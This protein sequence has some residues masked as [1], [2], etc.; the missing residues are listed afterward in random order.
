MKL[1]D[2]AQSTLELVLKLKQEN[3]VETCKNE[4]ALKVKLSLI[5]KH[6]SLEKA[7]EVQKETRLKKAIEKYGSLE[8]FYESRNKKREEV[9]LKKCG[10][11]IP[12]LNLN[13]HPL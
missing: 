3:L 1:E 11:K 13:P 12:I 9:C 5:K 4:K 10:K 6:G 7:Y 8:N 2:L